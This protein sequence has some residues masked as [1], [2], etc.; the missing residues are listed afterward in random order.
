MVG[1][2]PHV[3][4][5]KIA[6]ML[7]QESPESSND[8]RSR[9]LQKD[10]RRRPLLKG[11]INTASVEQERYP[12][13]GQFPANSSRVSATQIEV[14]HCCRQIRMV[15]MHER[16]LQIAGGKYMGTCSF[17]ARSDV[18]RDDGFVLH[19]KDDASV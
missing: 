10:G 7:A 12:P 9:R 11:R 6:A 1:W 2:R 13:V 14:Q 17:Q 19:H 8:A 16:T 3:I 18:E 5:Y 4:L 15:G